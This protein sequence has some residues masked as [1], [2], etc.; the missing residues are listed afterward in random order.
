MKNLINEQVLKVLLICLFLLNVIDAYATV[1]WIEEGLAYEKNPIMQEWLNLG[2]I[3]FIYIKLFVGSLA[4]IYLWT[5]RKR[6]ITQILTMFVTLVY[7]YVFILHC[8]FAYH[9]FYN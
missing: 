6:Q 2:P 7:V 1:Y 5:V 3:V 8:N 9:T 4:I